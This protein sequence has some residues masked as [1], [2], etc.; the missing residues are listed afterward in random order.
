[1]EQLKSIH[2]PIE[3][4]LNII[5]CSL[6]KPNVLLAP[7]HPI[8]QLL[9]TFTLVCRETR[10]LA[11]RYLYQHCIYLSSQERLSSLLLTIPSRPALRNISALYLAPFGHT[12]DDQPVAIW[13]RELFNYTCH[14]LKR[15]IIDMPLR[16]LYPEDDHLGVRDILRQGFLR[17][18]NLEEFVSVR[19]E[20]FLSLE[21]DGTEPQFWRNFPKLK[22]LALYNPDI[23]PEF[24]E[25]VAAVTQLECLVLTRADGLHS[26]DGS[27]FKTEYFRHCDR[28]LKVLLV[29]TDSDQ[30]RS[31]NMRRERWD[32]ID[33]T[34]KML[35]MTYNIPLLFEDDNPIEVCQVYVKTGAEYGTI[36]NWDGE[37]IQH[38]PKFIQQRSSGA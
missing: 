32:D 31:G 12:I 11:T 26:R 10:K 9:V 36:W 20:I 6:P 28:P 7:A 35:I 14:T 21:H 24:W 17:L 30:I 23:N 3:L 38:R 2:L 15:L 22:R 1:M 16:S 25:D 8:T 13:V 4:V 29:N 19:D 5:T 37:V 34:K 33:P 18:E 27:N